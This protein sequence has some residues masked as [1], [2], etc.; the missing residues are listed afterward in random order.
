MSR[1][2]RDT[3]LLLCALVAVA[4]LT[5]GTVF[6][7]SAAAADT[8]EP[9]VNDGT[10]LNDTVTPGDELV[11]NASGTD[12]SNIVEAR[13]RLDLEGSNIPYG[14]DQ[15]SNGTFV[16]ERFNR[17][18]LNKSDIR[19]NTTISESRIDGTYELQEVT[20]T[21]A[22]GNERSETKYS[23]AWDSVEIS[24]PNDPEDD[25]PDIQSV[26]LLNDTVEPGEKVAVDVEAT[27][28]SDIISISAELELKDPNLDYNTD[29]NNQLN[30][31]ANETQVTQDGTTTLTT[32]VPETLVEGSY[33]VDRV[34]VQDEYFNDGASNP[35]S[36]FNT[37]DLTV[38]NGVSITDTADPTISDVY[39]LNSSVQPGEN[40]TVE[41][42]VDKAG[43]PIVE[44]EAT[45]DHQNYY[46]GDTGEIELEKVD[47]SGLG[48][49]IRLTT[50]LD[51]NETVEG[52]YQLND[53]SVSITDAAR[54]TQDQALGDF[55]KTVDVG[56]TPPDTNG[57]EIS[58][59]SVANESIQA[60][61]ELVV[62]A[63]VGDES[64]IASVTAQFNRTRLPE[65][66][67]TPED[68]DNDANSEQ[69][70][71]KLSLTATNESTMTPANGTVNLTTTVPS[72]VLSGDYKLTNVRAT[73]VN[74]AVNDDVGDSYVD[75]RY[76]DYLDVN[77]NGEISPLTRVSVDAK[78]PATLDTTP[79]EIT[80]FNVLNNT[81][82][83]GDDL[84]VELN[85]TDENGLSKATVGVGPVIVDGT[86]GALPEKT[87]SEVTNI[88]SDTLTR[89]ST[90]IP[91]S[92][93]LGTV[94]FAEGNLTVYDTDKNKDTVD[95]QTQIKIGTVVSTDPANGSYTSI[96]NAIDNAS[97]G[98][99]IEVRSGTYNE[100]L[101]ID[102]DLRLVASDGATLDGG[103][104]GSGTTAMTAASAS[105]TPTVEGFT[106]TD[107]DHGIN[108]SEST[109]DWTVSDTA[110]TGVD[111][112]ISANDSTG[113]WTLDNVTV[114]DSTEYGL[115]A[116]NSSGDWTAT[117]LNI[118]DPGGTGVDAAGAAG[119]WG[120]D[121]T[122]IH[123]SSA[124]GIAAADSSGN[125]TLE[126]VSL[127]NTTG[128]GIN[129]SGTTDSWTIKSSTITN[130]TQSNPVALPADGTGIYAADTTTDWS[131]TESIITDTAADG[132]NATAAQIAGNATRNYW[133]AT[134]GPSGAYAG[135][136]VSVVG[137]VTATPYYTSANLSN[138]SS[139]LSSNDTTTLDGTNTTVGFELQND[140]AA[141]KSYILNLSL[142]SG[143]TAVSYTDDGGDRQ[144]G[145]AKWL[146]QTIEPGETVE[147]TVTVDAPE[148]INGT[149]QITGEALIEGEDSVVATE[150]AEI[151]VL[152]RNLTATIA[153]QTIANGSETNITVQAPQEDGS[154]VDRTDEASY[155][156]NDTS[157][158]T[159]YSNGT[160]TAV[161][162]GTT[163]INA[164]YGSKTDNVTVTVEPASVQ[165]GIDEN[166]N[167]E[168]DD[169]EVLDAIEYWQNNEAVPRTDGKKIGDF[170]I[171]DLI[172][173]WRNNTE[174][175]K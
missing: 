85:A 23:P 108:A 6:A 58:N 68:Y 31:E 86:P 41:L 148:D 120:I 142:P 159:V 30:L 15:G 98:D 136:G 110:I 78:D 37:G 129:A 83:P 172:E 34:E 118:T 104:L 67:Q 65:P 133:G 84:V 35:D 124:T 101:T 92:S 167:G 134:N 141:N 169:I 74:G 147:P 29:F 81:V 150:T 5:V 10:I 95:P 33:R 153:D 12:A 71:S 3:L 91:E 14:I 140:R 107:Y 50:T 156:S 144:S 139:P 9:T 131:V 55:T 11:V 160:V 61:E 109:S 53:Y 28:A 42:V 48:D 126:N 137:N 158:A 46:G 54:N 164:T 26:S 94:E 128:Y 96:Q 174:Y 40:L 52:S 170:E 2:R 38:E 13:V 138:L 7:G 77:Q 4:T 123:N 20:L 157:V 76:G 62:T 100:E 127:T 132:L 145:E 143:W 51:P 149:Y 27:D 111:N 39:L 163:T 21:D 171:L 75:Y 114:V 146:W 115:D 130:V 49:T 99:T 105:V 165:Q 44:A 63:D 80:D 24:T 56:P 175:T 88:Q 112:A 64:G 32:T 122:V 8:S 154:F 151:T 60:G 18:G 117:D 162:N 36:D 70:E 113:N 59:I 116:T 22:A 72:G 57:P 168:I 155:D 166:N 69:I 45:L 102:K 103:S 43:S 1:C 93:P 25:G 161:G 79:P 66:Y 17:S 16:L 87:E 125:W 97:A 173:K 152:D 119:S 121:D 47:D 19:F 135:S 89:I 90:T 82:E 73:D 106:I